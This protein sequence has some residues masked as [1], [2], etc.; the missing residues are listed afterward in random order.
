MDDSI[1][2]INRLNKKINDQ[3]KEIADLRKKIDRLNE[4]ISY[5]TKEIK[6]AQNQINQLKTKVF[7]AGGF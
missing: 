5:S 6:D 4:L 7:F 1:N 2:E 3:A